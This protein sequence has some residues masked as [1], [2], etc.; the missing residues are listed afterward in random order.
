MK[1]YKNYTTILPNN[2]QD[3]EKKLNILQE[4]HKNYK[5]I[6]NCYIDFT[7]KNNY[8]YHYYA[9]MI[10]QI[11]K[12]DVL[13]LDIEINDEEF[14]NNL[15]L[16]MKWIFEKKNEISKKFEMSKIIIIPEKINYKLKIINTILFFM[17]GIKIKNNKKTN[18]YKLDNNNVWN[19][20]PK[21]VEPKILELKSNLDYEF[22]NIDDIDT[23]L[24]DII[25]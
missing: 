6:S 7:T 25:I 2:E 15:D 23:S 20:L 13:N 12:F 16:C 10:I 3:V 11:L 21:E 14:I 4:N 18:F 22:D 24:L 5:W 1:W 19:N 17:Y 9:Q 8:T